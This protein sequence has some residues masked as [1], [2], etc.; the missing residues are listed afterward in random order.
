MIY[1]YINDSEWVRFQDA[2]LMV[3]YI[4]IGISFF[5][6]EKIVNKEIKCWFRGGFGRDV[7]LGL[8]LRPFF[9]SHYHLYLEPP[10]VV[11]EKIFL[12]R[13]ILQT[14]HVSAAIGKQNCLAIGE[15]LFAISKPLL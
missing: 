12:F 4:V 9:S 6:K 13:H 3:G 10:R 8:V 14:F 7:H 11:Y 1:E 15:Q 5:K 2:G